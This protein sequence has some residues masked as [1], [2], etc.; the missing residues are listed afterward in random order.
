MKKS[1]R[2]RETLKLVDKTKVYEIPEAISVLKKATS[3]K[4]NETVELAFHLMMSEKEGMIVRGVASLPYGTGK[5]V[6]VLVLTISSE[7]AK[8]ARDAGADFVGFEELLEKIKNGWSD[9]DVVIT[10]PDSMKEV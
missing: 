4:F 9:F 3:T 6:K 10:T 5:K 1:K 8:E 2:Y 7:K